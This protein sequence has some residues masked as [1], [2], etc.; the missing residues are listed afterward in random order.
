MTKLISLINA[1]MTSDM[2]IFKIKTKSKKQKIIPIIIALYLMFVVGVG[3]Y[4]QFESFAQGNLAH[5]ILALFVFGISFMT[6]IEGIYKSGS[7]IF[8]CKDDQLL[9]SLPIKRRTV[10]F[11]RMFKFYVFELLFNS[12]I[13]LPVMITYAICVGNVSFSY[14]VTSFIMFLLLP[15]IPIV[16]SCIIGVITSSFASRFKYKNITEIVM[17]MLILL[18]VIFASFNMSNIFGYIALN[19][20]TINSVITKIYYPAGIYAKLAVDFNIMDLIIFILIN[21]VIFVGTLIILSKFYF[22]INSRVKMVTTTERKVNVNELSYKVESPTIALI[23]KEINTFFKIP[24]LTI[25]AGF[26]LVLEI[27]LT[28]IMILKFDA[29]VSIITNP[30]YELGITSDLIYSNVSLVILVIL[31]ITAFM[32]SITSSVISLE[33]RNFNIL[34]SLPVKTKTILMSKA[35]AALV[36]TSPIIVMS[37]LILAII[38]HISIL[39]ILFLLI[40]SIIVPLVSHF[41]G[42]IINL[43][44]P[45]LEFDNPTEVVKQ[46]MSSFLSV[47]LGM[48]LLM[49]NIGI[50]VLLLGK[51][52]STLIL[53]IVTTLFIIV[54]TLLYLYLTKKSVKDFNKLSI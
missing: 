17:S 40:L 51:T 6:F 30:E 12:M 48:I 3:S 28:I 33:G 45:K 50:I 10:F 42:L 20:D 39:D 14:Y 2:A 49:I 16:L 11:I 31:L 5:V 22:K 46:S 43:K 29:L 9:L 54:D 47:M 38:F 24:V 4:Y 41:L 21:V 34:K 1:T 23:K 26:A 37:S 53:L 13:L 7:L 8:N 32:T 27:I 44:Y 36:I 25:N 35:Y 18:V 19:A 15:I 52:N